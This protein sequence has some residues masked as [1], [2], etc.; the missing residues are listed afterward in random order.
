[1]SNGAFDNV[2]WAPVITYTGTD[3]TLPDGL[4]STVYNSEE[5]AVYDVNTAIV[6]PQGTSF[7]LAGKFTKLVTS[8]DIVLKIIASNDEKD[9][10]GNANPNYRQ[11]EIYTRF[12]AWNE[13]FDGE[14]RESYFSS[15]R[16]TVFE[17]QRYFYFKCGLVKD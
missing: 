17:F 12:F 3:E 13:S 11:Q 16:T 10:L 4:S 1:M 8:D 2:K 9:S 14:L 6:I 7:S 15:Q 5:G